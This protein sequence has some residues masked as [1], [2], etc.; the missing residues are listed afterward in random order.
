[1]D[2]ALRMTHDI[3]A[4]LASFFWMDPH[5]HV[6]AAHLTARGLDDVLLYHMVVSDLYAAGCAS[7]SRLDEDRTQEAARARIVEAL[8]YLSSA[9]NTFMA[10][11]VRTILA[12]LYNWR[13]AVTESNWKRLDG[14]IRERAGDDAWAREVMRRANVARTG[15]ELWRRRDSSADDLLQYSVEWAF[16]ARS[17]RGQADIPLFELE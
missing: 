1:M 8:P 5:T 4:G 2:T 9:R 11:G 15:T 6:D 7:G 3:D 17:Q 16:F 10:W 14:T 13:E 12:D